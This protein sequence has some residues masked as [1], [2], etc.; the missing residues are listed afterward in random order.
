VEFPEHLG[1]P[2]AVAAALD[3]VREVRA[4]RRGRQEALAAYQRALEVYEEMGYRLRVE[5]HASVSALR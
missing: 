3:T 4:A 5:V 2:N 1:D